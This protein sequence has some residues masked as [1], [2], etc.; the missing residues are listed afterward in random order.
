MAA[1]RESFQAGVTKLAPKP[2]YIDIEGRGEFYVIDIERGFEN[3]IEIG[4]DASSS[5]T[6]A[7]L[8]RAYVQGASARSL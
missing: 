1:A 5:L 4:R 3:A 2:E 8:L 7:L 6:H